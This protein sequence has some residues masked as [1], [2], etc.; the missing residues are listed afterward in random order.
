MPNPDHQPVQLDTVMQLLAPRS[1]ET[2]LD[3]TAGSGGHAAAIAK[4]IGPRGRLL[5]VDRDQAATKQLKQR[6]KRATIIH[7]DFD[8]V[9]SQL[10]G[11]G[12]DYDMI[13]MDL[14]V[15]SRQLEIAERG[16]SFKQPG[17]LDMRM[18]QRQSL[19]A[20]AI[21]NRFSARDLADLIYRYGEDRFAGRIAKALVEQRP[22]SDTTQLAEVV[23]GVIPSAVRRKSKIHP[24]TRTFQALRVAVNDELG[25]LSRTL[26][27]LAGLLRPGG[28]V[29]VISFHS[30]EDRLV[31]RYFRE[32]SELE[33]LTKRPIMGKLTD[34]YNPRA[35][36]SRLRAAIKNKK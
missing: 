26:P 17:P 19:N 23:A 33:V 27:R 18:D 11:S 28:R 5:L 10:V 2:Y 31:K 24:A 34:V 20:A 35:R 32:T 7:A 16:F 4:R 14:G 8:T 3:L 15:S 25:Q 1:G 6:F 9:T 21:V 12:T 13:L 22:L 29:A 30:L 36:S